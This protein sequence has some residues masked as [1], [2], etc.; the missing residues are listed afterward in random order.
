MS[1]KTALHTRL[2]DGFDV[3]SR[4]DGTVHT[5]KANSRTVAE[6]CVGKKNTRLNIREVPKGAP[7]NLDLG[8]KSKSWA[9]GVIVDASN[10]TACRALLSACVKAAPAAPAANGVKD[11]AKASSDATTAT[12]A[13]RK[14]RR[15]SAQ[16]AS[17]A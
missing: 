13:A 17:A 14:R 15:S 9:G 5:V 16:A 7:K 2:L 11:A 8:G 4:D 12:K 3:K 10:L 6:V 1:A